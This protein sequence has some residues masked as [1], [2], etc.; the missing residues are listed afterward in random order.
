MSGLWI[1]VQ[2]DDGLFTP[3][4]AIQRAVREAADAL[5]ALGAEVIVWA[6]FGLPV[7]RHGTTRELVDA[8][9]YAQAFNVLGVPAGGPDRPGLAAGSGTH[10]PG[11]K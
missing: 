11:S 4:P 9:G 6:P 8:A 1:R 7:A 10:V 2:E 3:S 5:T